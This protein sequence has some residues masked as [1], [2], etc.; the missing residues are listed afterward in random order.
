MR[1]FDRESFS[2]GPVRPT[3]HRATAVR[4]GGRPGGGAPAASRAQATH[5][6]RLPRRGGARLAVRVRFG[7]VAMSRRLPDCSPAHTVTVTSVA[8][9]P[10]ADWRYRVRAAAAANLASTLRILRHAAASGIEV[11]RLSSRL[12]PLATHPVYGAWPWPTEL[13]DDLAAVGA[14]VRAHGM[15]VSFHPDHFTP[16][17]S[18]R[19]EVIAAAERDWRDHRALFAAMGLPPSP[20]VVHLGGAT[21][22]RAAA[23]DRFCAHV[24][25]LPGWEGGL[26]LEN[27]DRVWTAGEVLEAGDRLRL[28]VVIDFL[29]AQVNPGVLPVADAVRAAAATWPPGLPPKVHLSSAA[30]PSRPRDHAEFVAEADARAALAVLAAGSAD[31]DVMI[32]AKGKDDA[33][34]RLMADA[35]AW[36]EVEVAGPA[37]LN[38][39]DPMGSRA[40]P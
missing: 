30:S 6:G 11:H 7:F 29:H 12:V 35:A 27:D 25:G 34:F 3:A 9:L 4:G 26:A 20:L 8:G 15:R 22:G 23:M 28:P 33:L 31:T 36:P 32:E 14:V 21:G 1:P 16:L 2:R 39:A 10:P 13:A 19:P 17:S 38:L 37:A 24:R 18:P 5:P 40:T